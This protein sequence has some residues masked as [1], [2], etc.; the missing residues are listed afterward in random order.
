VTGAAPGAPA[1]HG[2][3]SGAR[4]IVVAGYRVAVAT[5][6]P[7]PGAALS[8]AARRLA[9]D[10]VGERAGCPRRSVRVASLLPSG[11]PVAS[12]PVGLLPLSV[13]VSHDRG[14]VAAA[15]AD[16]TTVGVDVVDVTAVRAGLDH[17]LVDS[18]RS[19]PAS[20]G[21]L[22]AAKEAA[23]KAAGL[24]IPF[25][26]RAVTVEADGEGFTWTLGDRW[27]GA[28]GAGR[29]L[30]EGRHLVAVACVVPGAVAATP[31]SGD[32]TGGESPCS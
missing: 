30:A 8:V 10:L 22:W 12:G 5:A 14:L 15:T 11:R 18:E 20:P 3:R 19:S 21:M 1:R 4:E 9:E 27:R 7:A 17:W 31:G 23:Y 26:P 28:A 29:F 6:V 25:Q 24:D 2:A 32:V 16:E 13:S